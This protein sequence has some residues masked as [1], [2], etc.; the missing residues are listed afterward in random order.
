MPEPAPGRQLGAPQRA[1]AD[2]PGAQQRSR[3]HVVDAVG[4]PVGERLGTTAYSA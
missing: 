1:V 3:V 4:Q 2:D